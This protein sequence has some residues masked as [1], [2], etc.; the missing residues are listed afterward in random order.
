MKSKGSKIKGL[1][2]TLIVL[3]ILGVMAYF[4]F[5]YINAQKE[6]NIKNNIDLE[7]NTKN[8]KVRAEIEGKGVSKKAVYTELEYTDEVAPTEDAL[9]TWRGKAF[10]FEDKGDK[11]KITITIEY[12]SLQ[13]DSIYVDLINQ[14]KEIKG[15]DVTIKF[16]GEEYVAGT[17]MEVHSNEFTEIGKSFTIEYKASKEVTKDINTTLNYKVIVSE[18]PILEASAYSELSFNFDEEAKTASVKD[19]KST[20]SSGVLTIPEKIKEDGEIY[21]VTAIEDYA[22]YQKTF[23]TGIVLPKTITYI[24]ESAFDECTNVTSVSISNSVEYVGANAFRHINEDAYTIEGNGKYLGNSENKYLLLCGNQDTTVTT[25][26]VQEGCKFIVGVSDTVCNF[27]TVETI[28]FPST[29]VGI[30]DYVFLNSSL[31]EIKLPEGLISIGKMAFRGCP[32]TSVSIPNSV[33]EIGSNA[34]YGMTTDAYTLYDN[35]KY[36]GNSKNPYLLLQA[37]SDNTMNTFIVQNDCKFIAD[38][39][40]ADCTNLKTITLVDTIKQIGASAFS[41]CI[42]LMMIDIPTGVE[43]IGD[44]TFENCTSLRRITLP[45]TIKTIGAAAFKSCINLIDIDL[46]KV[47]NIGE[48]AFARCNSLT[49]VTVPGTVETIFSTTFENCTGLTSVV[50]EDGVS[51]IQSYAFSGCGNLTNIS[52]PSNIFRIEAYAFD[53]INIKAY[54]IKNNG[55]YL[56]NSKNKYV[57]FVGMVDG[58]A[59]QFILASSTRHILDKAFFYCTNLEEIVIPEEVYTVGNYAFEGCSSLKSIVLPD[60]IHTLGVSIFKDCTSLESAVLP[61]SNVDI[62][63][64]MFEGCTS[65]TSV[66]IPTRVRSIKN[67]AFFGCTKLASIELHDRIDEIGASAF[68][69][70]GLTSIHIKSNTRIED[71]AFAGCTA[72]ETIVVDTPQVVTGISSENDKGGLYKYAKNVYI[73]VEISEELISNYF[74]ETAGLTKLETSDKEGYIQYSIVEETPEE[75]P[76]TPAE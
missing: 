29:L 42:N 40:F 27:S 4:V 21:T 20:A 34:F 66:T 41:G 23:I 67:S 44:Y 32:A 75:T 9:K 24:G 48:G 36:L 6:I 31:K 62:T 47:E 30:G 33:E 28:T 35:G 8:T 37:V 5:G 53:G 25:F 2:I 72:L 71:S 68:E 3:V 70:C 55:K 7:V 54:N 1:I 43:E 16:D 38:S 26:A 45:N 50:I 64:S 46:G 11:A 58:D 51:T 15:L 65:L 69:N 13:N 60:E 14:N 74:T 22:C 12:A 49:E 76:E 17:S 57:A 19:M 59:S 10:K 61:N 18:E 63:K 56:G 39:V 52:I 73:N